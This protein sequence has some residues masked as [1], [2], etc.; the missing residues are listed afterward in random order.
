[1]K[2]KI[3]YIAG[4]FLLASTL[5]VQAQ[6]LCG[7][8]KT[9]DTRTARLL[10]DLPGAS[11]SI[12]QP[13]KCSIEFSAKLKPGDILGDTLRFTRKSAADKWQ[14]YLQTGKDIDIGE[15][16]SIVVDDNDSMAVPSE[17]LSHGPYKLQNRSYIDERVTQIVVDQI[18]SGKKASVS[19]TLKGGKSFSSLFNEKWLR[20]SKQAFDWVDCMQK[21]K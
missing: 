15:G 2:N 13:G 10:G 18:R 21:G 8:A 3:I 1:M 20:G 19:A 7:V 6:E 12:K 17:F 9:A 4:A 11:C 16:I 5:S 14:I